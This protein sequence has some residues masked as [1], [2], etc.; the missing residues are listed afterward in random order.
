M[1]N[2]PRDD[3]EK[4][5]WSELVKNDIDPDKVFEAA[6]NGGAYGG[7]HP[8]HISEYLTAIIDGT[9]PWELFWACA[10]PTP[11]RDHHYQLKWHTV[12]WNDDK[13]TWTANDRTFFDI[14]PYEEPFAAY[15]HVPAAELHT[16][17]KNR[18]SDTL[19]DGVHLTETPREEL[20]TIASLFF[21]ELPQTIGS[22][23]KIIPDDVGDTY[24]VVWE[25]VKWEQNEPGTGTWQPL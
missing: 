17:L 1:P 23:M 7:L 12:E 15:E 2:P 16:W 9:E 25:V 3:S 11:I 21:E 24:H 22:R 18:D 8:P 19:F 20:P 13:D 6:Q 4:A 5:F 10:G 14:T